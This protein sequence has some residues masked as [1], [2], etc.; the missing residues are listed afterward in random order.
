MFLPSRMPPPVPVRSFIS[1]PSVMRVLRTPHNG[2]VAPL[3]RCAVVACFL[4]T[5]ITLWLVKNAKYTKKLILTQTDWLSSRTP[6][7]HLEDIISFKRNP[8]HSLRT[9][10]TL[11]SGRYI[12]SNTLLTASDPCGTGGRREAEQNCNEQTQQDDGDNHDDVAEISAQRSKRGT[13]RVRTVSPW[14]SAF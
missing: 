10:K 2:A 4:Q 12:I 7:F 5:R 13:P 3:C 8:K 1:V 11:I 9:V 14:T 6:L